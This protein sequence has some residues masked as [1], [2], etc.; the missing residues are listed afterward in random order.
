MKSRKAIPTSY[1]DGENSIATGFQG[2]VDAES[3][4]EVWITLAV[5]PDIAKEAFD[6]LFR[7]ATLTSR[8]WISTGGY[9]TVEHFKFNL[10]TVSMAEEK[11]YKHLKKYVDPMNGAEASKWGCSV[12]TVYGLRSWLTSNKTHWAQLPKTSKCKSS[13]PRPL[14]SVQTEMHAWQQDQ[15]V[16][17]ATAPTRSERT[18]NESIHRHRSWC[19]QQHPGSHNHL[20]RCNKSIALDAK[21][22][23]TGMYSAKK[24]LLIRWA[25]YTNKS[26]P[27]SH[28]LTKIFVSRYKEKYPSQRHLPVNDHCRETLHFCIYSCKPQ[29]A[30]TTTK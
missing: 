18:R 4:Q 16:Q 22:E 28:Y 6:R 29:P 13:E 7:S 30:V 17:D 21:A 1:T 20:I 5:I 23:L 2:V 14:E 11:F 15:V 24:A 10:F 26:W 25:T 19:T 27:K 9:L 12:T 3:N 8:V